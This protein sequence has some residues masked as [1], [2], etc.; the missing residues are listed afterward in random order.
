MGETNP[1][2]P[3]R[4]IAISLEEADDN[5]SGAERKKRGDIIASRPLGT[6]FIGEKEGKKYIW[7]RVEGLEE[8][9]FGEFASP[10]Y[11]PDDPDSGLVF[12]KR[13]Y[14]IPLERL[15]IVYPA[16]N[17]ARAVDLDDFYQPFFLV[18]SEDFEIISADPPFVVSGLVF[19]KVTGDYL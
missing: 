3:D 19:D 12:D 14:N 9:E 11:E 1:T 16:F 10:V 7:L 15:E 13:R 8:N 17:S 5:P 18:D 2:Y 6:S 4:E